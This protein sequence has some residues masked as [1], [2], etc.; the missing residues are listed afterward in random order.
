GLKELSTSIG[1]A[2]GKL[3]EERKGTSQAAPHIAHLAAKLL[4][5]LPQA[6]PN[7]LRAL[8]VAHARHH[9]SWGDLFESEELWKVCGYGEILSECLYRSTEQQVTLMMEDM[10]EDRTHHFYSIPIPEDFYN[11]PARVRE[12]TVALAYTPAVRTTRIDYKASRIEFKLIEAPSL[13]AAVAAFN[14]NTS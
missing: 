1:F 10:I 2:S 12:I 11:G 8:L 9:E 3:V 4:G 5:E 14:A 7:L 6:S 13:D